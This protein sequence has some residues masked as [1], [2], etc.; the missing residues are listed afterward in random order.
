M[1]KAFVIRC[2]ECYPFAQA[3]RYGQYCSPLGNYPR[4]DCGSCGGKGLT[5]IPQSELQE[6]DVITDAVELGSN[7]EG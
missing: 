1:I 6:T 4:E 5:T 3:S 7:T 2:R